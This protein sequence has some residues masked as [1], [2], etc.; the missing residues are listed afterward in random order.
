VIWA[1]AQYLSYARVGAIVDYDVREATVGNA[2]S[3]VRV[4]AHIG[5]QEIL[6]VNAALGTRD[7]LTDQWLK[8][9]DV[10]PPDACPPVKHW[11]GRSDSVHGRFETRLAY[12]RYP[13]GAMEG[14]RSD[15]A[16]LVTWVRARDGQLASPELLAVLADFV[17]QAT[18]NAVGFSAGGNSLDNTIRYGRIQPTDWVMCDIRIDAIVSGLI[19]GSINLFAP[20]GTLMATASQSLI[21]RIHPPPTQAG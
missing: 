14:G 5:D 4:T 6:T 8:A 2:I 16:R 18:S 1:T 10:A 7:G 20:D 12:G 11:R 3:Q 9:P 21:L 15:D 13:T 19:H 17:P